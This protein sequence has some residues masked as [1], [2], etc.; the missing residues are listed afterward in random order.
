MSKFSKVEDLV[1]LILKFYPRARDDDNYLFAEY[2]RLTNPELLEKSFGYVLAHHS[3][4]LNI[5]SVE[6]AR[7]KIQE[8]CPELRGEIYDKRHKKEQDYIE[9]SRIGGNLECT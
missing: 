2:V 4:D 6:R 9:Y 1:K 3:S 8:T 7:R 5:K